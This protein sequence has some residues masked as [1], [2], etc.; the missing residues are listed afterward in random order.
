MTPVPADMETL[1]QSVINRAE[2]FHQSCL[3]WS[4]MH[5][6]VSEDPTDRLETLNKNRQLHIVQ[7]APPMSLAGHLTC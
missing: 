6:L 2:M 1:T 7:N 3:C 5:T 4:T